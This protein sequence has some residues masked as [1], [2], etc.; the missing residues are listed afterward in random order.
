MKH[1]I[2]HW[3]AEYFKDEDYDDPATIPIPPKELGD[4]AGPSTASAAA[5]RNGF[6]R[7]DYEVAIDA[8]KVAQA[9]RDVEA[10][11]QEKKLAEAAKP[12]DKAELERFKA[13]TTTD[14]GPEGRPPA[15]TDK[16]KEGPKKQITMTKPALGKRAKARHAL[17]RA[18]DAAV[19]PSR[20]GQEKGDST[21]L[22]RGCSR[23]DI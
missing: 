22:Q 3:A 10:A 1:V 13:T 21:S 2:E 9:E 8:A 14:G 17:R 11:A 15:V 20:P 4:H 23:S 7:D 6:S 16:P 19:W 5:T 18:R 12:L